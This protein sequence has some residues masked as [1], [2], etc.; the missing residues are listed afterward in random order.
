LLRGLAWQSL[1]LELEVRA[2]REDER[3]HGASRNGQAP[4]QPHLAPLSLL[5]EPGG[6]L[7]FSVPSGDTAGTLYEGQEKPPQDAI[8]AY[9]VCCTSVSRQLSLLTEGV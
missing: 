7:P 2:A 1:R 9:G 5:G 3:N 4:N 6:H 8:Q